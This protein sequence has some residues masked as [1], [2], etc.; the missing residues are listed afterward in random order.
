MSDE[1]L[2]FWAFFV[3]LI[4]LWMDIR[5]MKTDLPQKTLETVS[6]SFALVKADND[7]LR[8]REAQ[9]LKYID[10]LWEWIKEL[11]PK[12]AKPPEKLDEYLSHFGAE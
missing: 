1:T 9:L 11:K 2:G 10:Y 3:T 7:F 8:A 5:K 4:A 12:R 6:K